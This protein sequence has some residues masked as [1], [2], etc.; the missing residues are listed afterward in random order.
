MS[1]PSLNLSKCL[2]GRQNR[3]SDRNKTQ[4]TLRR[5]LSQQKQPELQVLSWE[6]SD[7][8]APQVVSSLPFLLTRLSLNQLRQRDLGQ[9]VSPPIRPEKSDLSQA[10]S[11]LLPMPSRRLP[12]FVYYLYSSYLQKGL[13]RI[14]LKFTAIIIKTWVKGQEHYKEPMCSVC[15]H[16]TQISWLWQLP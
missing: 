1:G 5:G 7:S 2:A 9:K 11:R 6:I 3:P 10:K 12:P 16:F 8:P 15:S 13:N 14:I 4:P